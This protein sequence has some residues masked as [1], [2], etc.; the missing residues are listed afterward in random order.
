[1]IL[2]LDITGKYPLVVVTNL[3][4]CGSFEGYDRVY[5]VL[6]QVGPFLEHCVVMCCNFTV[7]E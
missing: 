3:N 7:S 6:L 4:L 1:M 2:T 5:Y